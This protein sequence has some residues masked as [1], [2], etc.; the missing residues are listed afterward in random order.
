MKLRFTEFSS[1]LVW[2]IK[3][4]KRYFKLVRYLDQLKDDELLVLAIE[5]DY[6]LNRR[7]LK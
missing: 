5:I 4:R 7:N 1:Y 6:I 3:N 2:C